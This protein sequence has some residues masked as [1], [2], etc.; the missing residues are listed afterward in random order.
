MWN[1]I[2]IGPKLIFVGTLIV[3]MPIAIVAFFAVTQASAALTGITREQM[4]SRAKE[5]A[6][7]IDSVFLAEQKMAVEVSVGN[8]TIAGAMAV[9]E[10]GLAKSDAEIQSLNQKLARF[11]ATK[12]LGEDYQA[13]LV[14]GM[15]GIVFSAS[16]KDHYGVSIAES[17]Y[18]Q[19]A[20]AGKVNTGKVAANKATGK[21][22]VP[23][24][25]PIYSGSG[26][27][28]GVLANFV[29][30]TALTDM[31]ASAKMGKTGYA[32]VINKE[33]IIVAHPVKD[34]IL[35]LNLLT[36]EGMTT[37][38]PKM[39]K[40]ES[41]VDAYVFQGIA[42]TAGY[43][44][45]AITGWSVGLTVP[46]V[47]FLASSNAI[48]N[49]ILMIAGIALVVA[50]LLF[51]LFARSI[52][53]PL[54]IAVSQLGEVAQGDLIRDVDA[55]FIRRKDEIGTLGKAMD[56]LVGNLRRIMGDIKTASDQVASGSEQISSTAQQM[57]Q[58]A[59][60]Q[61]A[62]AEEVSASI[63]EMNA[64][65][66]QNADNSIATEGIARKAAEDGATGGNTVMQAVGAMNEIASRISIIDEIARNTNLLALNAAIE[67]ARAGEAGKGFA[68]VASEVRKLAERS[69][70]AAGEITELS[71]STV[72]TATQAGALIQKIVPDIRKTSELIQEIS[73][74]SREQST[75][76]DQIGR[77]ITQLDNVIQ[78]NASASEE[79]ASMAQELSGQS[80]QLADAIAFFKLAA[81]KDKDAGTARVTA[82]AGRHEVKV[83]HIKSLAERKAI[84]TAAAAHAA[85]SPHVAGA[86]QAKPTAIVLKAK[87]AAGKDDDDFE[88]F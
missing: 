82:D 19:Q 64:S 34:N 33:G 73:S 13:V 24:A 87:P 88:E 69:Q 30:I 14:A 56:G 32:F 53:K 8:A 57:S 43:A 5:Y 47:E 85:E 21:P 18:F 38:T 68:V 80:V 44:P 11:I 27:V 6:Q 1:N 2:K 37:F 17:P 26:A 66:K 41:G 31:I 60:E 63:E 25:S 40:G 51:F 16:S 28:I 46:D 3:L 83:A 55:S 50:F 35:K 84:T 62:S 81:N 10:K 52:S 71:K 42:K 74:A 15:D 59:T 7:M 75:G 45:S 72:A 76:A 77:A 61:A 70:K 67:A 29:D 9:A 86:G 78:Q 79:M 48:R 36:A 20:L 54:G 65:I 49:L 22:F 23:V 12:G 4:A 39:V 58:G